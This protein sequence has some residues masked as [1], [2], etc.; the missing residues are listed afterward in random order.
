MPWTLAGVIVST[1]PI[2]SPVAGLKD[3]S[4]GLAFALR[5]FFG[6]SGGLVAVRADFRLP[7]AFGFAARLP[8]PLARLHRCVLLVAC[9]RVEAILPDQAAE[10]NGGR[11]QS[12][13]SR[14]PCPLPGF[15]RARLRRNRR[16]LPERQTGRR[17]RPFRKGCAA[18]IAAIRL[19]APLIVRAEPRAAA[20]AAR[21][22][23]PR[24]RGRSARRSARRGP[25]PGRA[26]GR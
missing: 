12:P 25:T 8:A 20:P 11:E 15:L 2:S 26:A 22:A 9:A 24:S 4:A 1:V 6:R 14:P 7:P 21:A 18:R 13:S 3:S 23:P 5:R 10:R 17:T 19:N 16:R